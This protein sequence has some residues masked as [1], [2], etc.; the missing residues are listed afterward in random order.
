MTDNKPFTAAAARTGKILAAA[1]LLPL[2]FSSAAGAY[3][4]RVH[5]PMVR[6]AAQTLCKTAPDSL[7]CLEFSK[8]LKF[9]V[10]GARMEDGFAQGGS[11]VLDEQVFNDEDEPGAY[12]SM[13]GTAGGRPYC[14]HYWFDSGGA[15]GITMLGATNPDTGAVLGHIFPTRQWDS[16]WGRAVKI[17]NGKV[18]PYYA[19]GNYP[20]AYY[21]LGRVAHLLADTG[22]PQHVI[23]H[24]WISMT[25]LK[26]RCYELRVD[27]KYPVFAASGREQGGQASFSK[28]DPYSLFS[29]MRSASR[30][31]VGYT[32]SA[33]E[34]PEVLT[35]ERLKLFD[36]LAVAQEGSGGEGKAFYDSTLDRACGAVFGDALNKEASVLIP[37]II[38]RTASLFEFFYSQAPYLPPELS[39]SGAGQAA[40]ADI[41]QEGAV[42]E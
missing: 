34:A 14:T 35:P 8:Y 19:N 39:D 42:F 4:W 12:C 40:A 10:F 22:V 17:W 23:P 20:Q 41:Q 31:A 26:H 33:K 30:E 21:W 13:R 6:E 36:E 38:T 5:E 37:Q 15:T 9:A 7:P 28:S 27:L 1:L 32:P 25:E 11:Y 18:L 24:S 29:D 3:M 16:T 2:F